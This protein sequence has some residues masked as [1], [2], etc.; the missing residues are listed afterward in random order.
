MDLKQTIPWK[1]IDCA[2]KHLLNLTSKCIET[3][4]VS[5]NTSPDPELISLWN[6]NVVERKAPLLLSGFA[7]NTH[8]SPKDSIGHCRERSPLLLYWKHTAPVFPSLLYV[9]LIRKFP[10]T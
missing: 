7:V 6:V 3:T 9:V 5:L 10:L 4:V 1:H 8:I 2:P